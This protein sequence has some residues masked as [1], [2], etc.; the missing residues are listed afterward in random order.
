M[1]FYE[2]GSLRNWIDATNVKPLMYIHRI[3][4]GLADA[5]NSMHSSGL[6]HNDIKPGNILVH[7]EPNGQII[8]KL[9]DF[10]CTNVV[11]NTV[12]KVDA[13]EIGESHG[14]SIKYAPPERFIKHYKPGRYY[15]SLNIEILFK[16]KNQQMCT[17]HPL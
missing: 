1:V 13:F 14:I 7:I 4:Y 11:E 15:Y 5:L 3:I 6:V 2:N 8:P 16:L 9:T 17:V 10:G 12:L